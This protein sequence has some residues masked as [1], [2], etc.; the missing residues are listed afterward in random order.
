L[1]VLLPIEHTA[2]LSTNPRVMRKLQITSQLVR[3]RS[4][5]EWA[6]LAS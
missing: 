2:Q 1:R 6:I 4:L 3:T 5:S